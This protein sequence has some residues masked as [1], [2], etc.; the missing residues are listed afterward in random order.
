MRLERSSWGKFFL[1]MRLLFLLRAHAFLFVFT[2]SFSSHHSASFWKLVSY[3]V[4]QPVTA[5]LLTL[6]LLGT[7]LYPNCNT[8][9]KSDQAAAGDD[10]ST[11]AAAAPCLEAPG[12]GTILGMVGVFSGLALVIL[13]EPP[14]KASSTDMTF[15]YEQVGRDKSLSLH[16]LELTW[17]GR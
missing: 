17:S 1:G 13:T 2:F 9:S 15:K 5:A 14:C 12:W 6:F 16:E 8:A 7:G 10:V 11:V 4:L 3:T